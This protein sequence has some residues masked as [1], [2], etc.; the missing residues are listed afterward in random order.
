MLIMNYRAEMLDLARANTGEQI[1]VLALARGFISGST[2]HKI[3]HSYGI[4]FIIPARTDM[5]VTADARGLYHL[6]NKHKSEEADVHG[7]ADLL[8]Y[9]EYA[10]ETQA[11]IN[12]IVVTRWKKK[13]YDQGAP[14][15]N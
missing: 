1:D 3:K 9:E 10:G 2:L 7:V 6:T 4:D 13:I 15:T 12:A 14:F 5:L 8:S 11:P